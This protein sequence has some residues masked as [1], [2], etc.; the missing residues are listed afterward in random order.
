MFSDFPKAEKHA[1]A[2]SIPWKKN[3]GR[4][5]SHPKGARRSWLEALKC[6]LHMNKKRKSKNENVY[7]F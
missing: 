4:A 6:T 2:Q 5:S 7:S 3:D 1:T